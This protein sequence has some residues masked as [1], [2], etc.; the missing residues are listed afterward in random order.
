LENLNKITKEIC[1]HVP[2]I[3][4]GVKF[5]SSSI[6]VEKMQLQKEY[7]GIRIRFEGYLGS[8]KIPMQ[9]DVG[10]GDTPAIEEYQ[11]PNL[12]D[13]PGPKLKMYP[14]ETLMAGKILT[15]VEKGETKR[16]YVAK[17]IF[18]SIKV[19]YRF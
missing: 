8:A 7:E 15:M 9:I 3:D 1:E 19:F 4:D 18:F 14:Q 2:S 11:Y 10:F 6:R 13:F 12:L 17:D 16:R 5:L